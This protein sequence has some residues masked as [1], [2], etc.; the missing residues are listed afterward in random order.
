MTKFLLPRLKIIKSTNNWSIF[1]YSA[2]PNGPNPCG[3]ILTIEKPSQYRVF[4]GLVSLIVLIHVRNINFGISDRVSWS[5][6]RS[7]LRHRTSVDVIR[8]GGIANPLK[9]STFVGDEAWLNRPQ[10]VWVI[11][12]V[13]L[14]LQNFFLPTTS[15]AAT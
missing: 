9:F 15:D 13:E 2:W 14:L 6:A 10:R 1:S 8:G 5:T 12:Q 3:L 7:M 4:S 11:K